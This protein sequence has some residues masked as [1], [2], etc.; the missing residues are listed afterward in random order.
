M[1]T[2]S[3]TLKMVLMKPW[4]LLWQGFALISR[5]S[6]WLQSGLCPCCDFSTQLNR[7]LYTQKTQD[8][9]VQCETLY[10]G[11]W[12]SPS[13]LGILQKHKIL[14][15]TAG[16]IPLL[17]AGE[18]EVNTQVNA[19]RNVKAHSIWHI[20]FSKQGVGYSA[21]AKTKIFYHSTDVW[22]FQC[23]F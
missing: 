4:W 3:S 1:Q 18:D 9:F 8:F 20:S 16:R 7:F 23:R 19:V 10:S 13:K 21:T 11:K 15:K 12:A 2:A 22:R 14:W 5:C 17:K 6:P